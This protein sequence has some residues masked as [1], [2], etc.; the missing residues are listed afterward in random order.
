MP[1]FKDIFCF[2]YIGKM[3]ERFKQAVDFV[4]RNKTFVFFLCFAFSLWLIILFFSQDTFVDEETHLRQIN[5]FLKGNFEI[6]PSLTTIPGYH[7]VIAFFVHFFKHPSLA[8]V[9]FISFLLSSSSLLAAYLISKKLNSKYPLIKTLQCAF[10]PVSFLYF[11]LIYTDIFSLLLVLL[12]LYS[13]LSGKYG[14]SALFSLAA[15]LVRQDDIIWVALIWTYAYLSTYGFSFSLKNIEAH[16]RRTI[17]HLVVFSIFIIF[18]LVNGGV[19][20]G[21]KNNHQVGFYMGNSYFFL[22]IVGLLFFP[23]LLAY[24]RKIDLSKIKPSML[25]G[26]GAGIVIAGSFIFIQPEIHHGNNKLSMLRNILLQSGYHQYMWMYVA[27]I[28]AGYMALFLMKLEKKRMILLPFIFVSLFP[29]LLVEQRYYIVPLF[30]LLL[31]RTESGKKAE[32]ALLSY[33]A[34]LSSALV[35]MIFYTGLFF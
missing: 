7:I 23:I 26:A 16:I 1:S 2:I 10:L 18:V 11:P 31:F 30:F 3:I 14:L 27:A 28:F 33:F 21:D 13:M 22:A 32:L 24:I 9:R 5:R 8:L 35:I 20:L 19:A 34:V 4:R 25:Y 12:A 17:G 15:I 29:S 6:L